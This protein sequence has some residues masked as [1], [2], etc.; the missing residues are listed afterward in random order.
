MSTVRILAAALVAAQL[1]AAGAA[2]AQTVG[3]D[4]STFYVTGGVVIMKRSAPDNGVSVAANPAGTPYQTGKDFK[5][6]WEAGF[7]GTIGV[8]LMGRHAVEFRY[9]GVDSDASN[10]F[11][12]PGNFIG[13]GFTG[14]GGT[15]VNSTYDT[16]LRNFELNWRY[17]W[18]DQ[19]SLLAG[20]R[21]IDLDDTQRI[22]LNTSVATGLYDYSN[23]LRGAQVGLDW[24]LLPKTNPLQVNLSGKLGLF[25]LRSEG[26]I[27]EFQGN[28]YIGGFAAKTD[29]AVMAGELGISVGYQIHKNVQLRAGYQA[30]L[31][32]D[33]GL[34]N[35]NSSAS[36]LNPSL[37]RSNIYKDS[38]F[39]HG[40]NLGLTVSW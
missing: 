2:N 33:V 36:L 23:Q 7:D 35:S 22:V 10:N 12:T 4:T 19:I 8:R 38:I 39:Y 17:R 34:A 14:P 9:L 27:Q 13:G 6:D 26:G 28:N 3:N 29:D 32:D 30:L 15:T 1:S 20:L 16:S 25:H 18:T 31:I 11:T 37:L 21:A 40:A 5:F 24:S